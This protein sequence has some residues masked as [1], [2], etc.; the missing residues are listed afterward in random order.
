MQIPAT[1]EEENE[2]S[3]DDDSSN[4]VTSLTQL[5][6]RTK[7]RRRVSRP[8]LGVSQY[9]T[10]ALAM[11]VC[12]RAVSEVSDMGP[13]DH[14]NALAIGVGRFSRASCCR[15]SSRIAFGVGDTIRQRR[16]RQW[17]NERR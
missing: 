12:S 16:G 9:R 10:S 13:N 1:S 6:V 4:H 2:E 14:E 7:V 8:A 15:L 3:G 11:P 5:V 17:S